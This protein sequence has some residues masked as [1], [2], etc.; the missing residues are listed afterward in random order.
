MKSVII[1]LW[2]RMAPRFE[3]EAADVGG[4]QCEFKTVAEFVN[5]VK[6]NHNL[7]PHHIFHI[8][9]VVVA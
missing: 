7:Y 3:V 5:S 6:N 9:D 2:D 8:T 4:M 1:Y